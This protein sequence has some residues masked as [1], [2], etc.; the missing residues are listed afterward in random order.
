MSSKKLLPPAPPA[1]PTDEIAVEKYNDKLRSYRKMVESIGNEET[2]Q[3]EKIVSKMV[4][5]CRQIC[6]NIENGHCPRIVD[7]AYFFCGDAGELH[8]GRGVRILVNTAKKE[9]VPWSE[10]INPDALL[11]ENLC[12]PFQGHG[13]L[14]EVGSKGK[15]L[16]SA[17]DEVCRIAASKKIKNFPKSKDHVSSFKARAK[18]WFKG[19]T[20]KKTVVSRKNRPSSLSWAGW[21]WEEGF[22]M[23]RQRCG[24]ANNVPK[25]LDIVRENMPPSQLV[26]MNM[27]ELFQ[28]IYQKD[29]GGTAEDVDAAVRKSIA[30]CLKLK[31][32]EE[33]SAK[34]SQE[35]KKANEQE[36]E[37]VSYTEQIKEALMTLRD[38]NGSSQR[39]IVAV[40]KTQLNKVRFIADALKQGVTDNVFTKSASRYRIK[41]AR[42]KDRKK[43]PLDIPKVRSKRRKKRKKGST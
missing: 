40:L 26:P 8:K 32:Q 11:L 15:Y 42:K 21:P 29:L 20:W 2:I 14:E 43:A 39:E 28:P 16:T 6:E 9:G 41:F 18:I 1:D 7:N 23:D 4:Q 17:V 27:L 35:K 13:L 33:A 34:K 38:Q 25:S 10:N 3:R 5:D 36:E 30:F 24:L 19:V 22:I 37:E 12:D 31:Q